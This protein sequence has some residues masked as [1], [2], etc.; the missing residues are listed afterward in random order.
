MEVEPS[1]GSYDDAAAG[2]VGVNVELAVFACGEDVCLVVAAGIGEGGE[3]WP[4]GARPA[5]ADD[6]GGGPAA[7]TLTGGAGAFVEPKFSAR[8]VTG[9]EIDVTVAG[10]VAWGQQVVVGP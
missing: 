2:E 4:K 3:Q 6:G 9:Q 10:A 1:A 7:Q 8:L 5:G